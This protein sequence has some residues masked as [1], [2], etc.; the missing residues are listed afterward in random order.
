MYNLIN[1]EKCMHLC[2]YNPTKYIE[3][4]S[5]SKNLSSPFPSILPLVK[6]CFD[7]YH[8]RLVLPGL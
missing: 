7:F 8:H 5:H 6:H 3:H 4:F 2:N 1:F